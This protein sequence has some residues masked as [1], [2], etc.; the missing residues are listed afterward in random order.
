M[1]RA[2]WKTRSSR[3]ARPS[4]QR[5]KR[6]SNCCSRSALGNS[7]AKEAVRQRKNKGSDPFSHRLKPQN[8]TMSLTLAGKI[9]LF[10]N[11]ALSILFAFLG[12]GVYTQRINR[13]DK[14]IG[15]RHGQYEQ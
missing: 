8:A 15:E 13:T 5:A 1:A 4:R 12:L 10:V 2:G 3:P 11:L 14:K 9:A 6:T 7:G